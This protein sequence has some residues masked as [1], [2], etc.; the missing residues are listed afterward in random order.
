MTAR[1]SNGPNDNGDLWEWSGAKLK[2]KICEITGL[3]MPNDP[4][5]YCRWSVMTTIQIYAQTGMPLLDALKLGVWEFLSTSSKSK[6]ALEVVAAEALG[7]P[8]ESSDWAMADQMKDQ[9]LVQQMILSL[10]RKA[11][12]HNLID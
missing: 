8:V 12:S 6:A 2:R 10:T 1:K 9:E 4:L 11:D 3:P 5:D 7:R